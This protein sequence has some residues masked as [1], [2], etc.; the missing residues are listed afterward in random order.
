MSTLYRRKD[1][2]FWWWSSKIKGKRLRMSTGMEKKSLAQQVKDQWDIKVLTGDLSFIGK[3]TCPGHEISAFMDEYRHVRSRISENTYQTARSV[4]ARFERFLTSQGVHSIEE[5]SIKLLDAY[6]DHL[7]LAPKTVHNHIKEIRIMLKRAVVEG[8][9]SSNPADHVTLP[10][11][12][13]KNRHRMLDPI[14]LQIIFDSAGSYRLFYEFL[15]Y[16]GLRAGDVAMLRHR[17]IDRKRGSITCLVRKSEQVHE[18]PLARVL[19]DRLHR[20]EYDQPLFPSLYAKTGKKASD[21]LRRPRVYMQALLKAKGRPKATLHSFRTTFNNTLRDLGLQMDDRQRLLAH[22]SSE[23]TK[24]YTQPNF[25]LA[26]TWVDR[27][28]RFSSV[29]V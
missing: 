4:S 15:Y 21:R 20:G 7:H 26:K 29:E 2:P 28:P 14:D 1:S 3:K 25:E 12:I 27:M 6:I 11:I 22:S 9:L 19:L 18:L 23:A 8:L 24:I 13:K 10:K 16:T 5:I 17:D